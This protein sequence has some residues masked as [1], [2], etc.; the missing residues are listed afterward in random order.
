MG[1]EITLTQALY[2]TISSMAIVFSILLLIS[3]VL[4]SF[5]S[6]FKEKNKP[7]LEKIENKEVAMTNEEDEEEKIVIA[8]A[9]SIMAGDG[10]VNPNLRIKSI[11]RIS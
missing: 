5:K 3:F 11:T 1:N 9:A 8:L 10:T 4:G 7:K 2:I 6:I